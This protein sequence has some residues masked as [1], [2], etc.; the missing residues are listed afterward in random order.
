M[1]LTHE[2]WDYQ[3]SCSGRFTIGKHVANWPYCVV[4]VIACLCVHMHV[5]IYS[6]CKRERASFELYWT[7]SIDSVYHIVDIGEFINWS[8]VEAGAGQLVISSSKHAVK[9]R[10]SLILDMSL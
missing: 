6:V 9:F 1:V 3:F 2:N 10:I 4:C 5:Y 8:F 7:V